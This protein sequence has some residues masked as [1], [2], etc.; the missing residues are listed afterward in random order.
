MLICVPALMVPKPI[1]LNLSSSWAQVTIGVPDGT[2][3]LRQ[4]DVIHIPEAAVVT[5][6]PIGR[7]RSVMG[8]CDRPKCYYS[9]SSADFGTLPIK[10]LD[11]SHR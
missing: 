4:Y 5:Q 3:A 9:T 1:V 6:E 7:M 10:H 2:Q 8:C 11:T